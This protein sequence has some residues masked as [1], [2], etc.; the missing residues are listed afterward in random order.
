MPDVRRVF[1]VILEVAAAAAVVSWCLWLRNHSCLNTN[2]SA[3]SYSVGMR[4]G[5][6]GV[7]ALA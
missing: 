5:M 4:G 1:R 2:T 6:A 7:A 3:E